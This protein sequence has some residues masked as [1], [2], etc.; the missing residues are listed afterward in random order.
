[1]KDNLGAVS[2][3]ATVTVSV[4]A[5]PTITAPAAARTFRNSPLTLAGAN[6]ISLSDIDANGHTEKV[7]L[8][9]GQGALTLAAVS[10]LT[11]DAGFGNKSGEIRMTG[12]LAALNAA[13]KRLRYTPTA[14]TAGV[15]ALQ[16]TVDDMGNPG[17]PGRRRP[18][19]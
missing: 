13:L 10:N 8:K 17:G 4:N 11:F 5:L 3:T 15:D 14:N 12:T 9:V 6:R 7:I 19:R 2:S 1:V 18:G 16:I